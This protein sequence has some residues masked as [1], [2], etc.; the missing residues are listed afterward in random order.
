M[1]QACTSVTNPACYLTII[2]AARTGLGTTAATDPFTD[3]DVNDFVRI[4]LATIRE[5]DGGE[6]CLNRAP[7]AV[8]RGLFSSP[9]QREVI[10]PSLSCAPDAKHLVDPLESSSARELQTLHIVV[11]KHAAWQQYFIQALD[12]TK[13]EVSRTLLH[14]VVYLDRA[15]PCAL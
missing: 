13:C 3:W 5:D 15:F 8:P 4:S 12:S 6:F 9:S 11:E 14:P 1:Q 10:A 2:D 7:R